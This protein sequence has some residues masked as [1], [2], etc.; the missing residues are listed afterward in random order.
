MN[1]VVWKL[2]YLYSDGLH[3]EVQSLSIEMKNRRLRSSLFLKVLFASTTNIPTLIGLN[4]SL[5]FAYVT[6]AGQETGMMFRKKVS[7][8]KMTLKTNRPVVVKK[9][10][11]DTFN[12]VVE[13]LEIQA[14]SSL[15]HIWGSSAFNHHHSE[16]ELSANWNQ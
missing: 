5:H 15:C 14:H 11:S 16:A 12:G 1:L 3:L 6:L 8:T 7:K 4:T 2:C 10:S 13:A 9:C